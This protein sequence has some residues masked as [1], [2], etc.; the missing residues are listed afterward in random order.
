MAITAGQRVT[1]FE[2]GNAGD[3][4]EMTEL[5]ERLGLTG[6]TANTDAFA[7]GHLRLVQSGTDLLLQ[8]DR[9]AGGCRQW[10]P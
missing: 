4:F 9:D 5:P 1:D 10:P 2:V 3:K 7:S 6:Y 8:V